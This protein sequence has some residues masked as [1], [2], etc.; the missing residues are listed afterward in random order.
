[1]IVIIPYDLKYEPQIQVLFE[2]PVAG[3][4]SL[5]L[6]RRPDSRVGAYIQTENPNVFIT[7]L[8]EQDLVIGIFNI[9]TRSIYWKGE[10]VCMPYYCDLRIHPDF[11]N[12]TVFRQM[13][14]FIHER[15]LNLDQ[16][17]ASSIVFSDNHKFL[18]IIEKRASGILS[19]LVPYY[20][21]ITDIETFIFKYTP[22]IFAAHR[23]FIRRASETD[24]NMMLAFQ[25]ENQRELMLSLNYDL[26][27]NKPYYFDQKIDNY[28]L[29]FDADKLVGVLGL[30]DTT[31]FKQTVIHKYNRL[32]R[33]I[34]PIYNFGARHVAIFP[35]LPK[36]GDILNYISIHSLVISDR[37]PEVF[38]AF[39]S[40]LTSSLSTTFMLTLDKRDPLYP[41]MLQINPAIRKE[42]H[43]FLITKSQEII[44]SVPWIPVDAPRI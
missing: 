4:V 31:S 14:R 44:K 43:Y 22:K 37:K 18:K 33:L 36:E 21:K 39:L 20:Q 1:M 13:L 2:I 26:V 42:G 29:C 28:I 7:L 34:R 25:E 17:P 41:T 38:K 27:G 10:I 8:K 24:I 5:S 15:E 11:Q 3:Y 12:G 19:N 16:I 32:L 9:G 23:F 6:Q 30:W 35:E 40:N